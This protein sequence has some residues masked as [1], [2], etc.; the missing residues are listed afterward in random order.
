MVTASGL[1]SPVAA[2]LQV[3]GTVLTQYH[4]IDGLDAR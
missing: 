2:V 4:L 1:L 3:G